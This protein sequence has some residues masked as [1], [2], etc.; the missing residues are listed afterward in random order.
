MDKGNG[1][2]IKVLVT[3]GIGASYSLSKNVA[4]RAGPWSVYS[5]KRKSTGEA[6]SV[7]VFDK[8]ALISFVTKNRLQGSCVDDVVD[9][10]KR[11]V[12]ALTK[13]RHPAIL[14]IIEPLEDNKSVL[15]FVTEPL[16]S[17]LATLIHRRDENDLDDLT[18]QKGLL[19]IIEGVLFLHN[20]AGMVHLDLQPDSIMVDSKGDWKLAG[21]GFMESYKT[22]SGEFF[23][24]Q[25]DPRLPPFVQLNLDYAAPE[26]VL[27]R[28]L[29]PSNDVFSIGV[30]ILT[31]YLG[32][33]PM[34][35]R[36]NSSSYREQVNNVQRALKDK[37][38]PQYL[39]QPLSRVVAR[40]PIE[41][42]SLEDLKRSDF[43]DNTLIRSINFL[44]EFPGKLL[45]E[46]KTFLNGLYSMLNQFPKAILQKKVLQ[47]LIEELGKEEG[48][49]YLVLKNIFEIG[50]DMS[51]LGFS[52]KILPSITKVKDEFSGQ[53]A[54]ID[55]LE[56]LLS[57]LT[58]AEFKDSVLPIILK[59][60]EES[61]PETQA[62]VLGKVQLFT[63]DLDFV[64]LKNDVFPS[65][66]SVFGKTTS[67]T[68]KLRALEAF[69]VLITGDGLDKYTITEKL[70]PLLGAMKTRE[71][72][73]IMTALTVYSQLTEIVDVEVLAKTIVPQL[74]SLSMESLLSREQFHAFTTKIKS[75]L[76]RIE[77]DHSKKLSQTP[78]NSDLG[79][80]SPAFTATNSNNSTGDFHSLLFGSTSTTTVSTPPIQPAPATNNNSLAS[81]GQ[82][83][84]PVPTASSSTPTTTT[85]SAGY[86]GSVL[87]AS[88]TPQTSTTN[89]NQP[90]TP[91]KSSTNGPR[92]LKL[93]S[94]KPGIDWSKAT[95]PQNNGIFGSF[96]NSP[97]NTNN[98]L[99]SLQ[100][101]SN[102]SFQPTTTTIPT[103]PKPTQPSNNFP[104]QRQ[105]QQSPQQK[106]GLDQYQSLL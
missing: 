52:E 64:T 34:S 57:R 87:T 35:T 39:S 85:T 54:V 10:L 32:H 93:Q 106:K 83:S 36:N 100:A 103:L 51:Q 63:K 5:G 9:R 89:F 101:T 66:S 75:I 102:N 33:S 4:F 55:H 99:N 16:H 20:N 79:R 29:D 3:S 70:L 41:R 56:I 60:M 17:C 18:I 50:K 47:C 58:N 28:R 8:K 84:N 82:H 69:N 2:L 43:F 105:E 94:S 76:D 104:Q 95:Q 22:S 72:K 96:Q 12:A 7:F 37:A 24:S 92:T 27:D 77:K 38:I 21:F 13:I 30:L 6:V 88:L 86:S 26:L 62:T 42:L 59:S 61:P 11:E 67:L 78:V 49:S 45:S 15:M 31:I 19:Q 25:F 44:D 97:T 65:I 71:P 68:V 90:L 1:L 73:I 23:I 81:L 48:L 80:Q 40:S 98:S 91:N 74:L 46:K 14:K 53:T